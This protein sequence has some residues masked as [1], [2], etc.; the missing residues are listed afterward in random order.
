V[1]LEAMATGVPVV[2]ASAGGVPE[3]IRDGETGFLVRPDDPEA[4]ADALQRIW[5]D[6]SLTQAVTQRARKEIEA[7]FDLQRNI[8]ALIALL[9]GALNP[10]AQERSGRRPRRPFLTI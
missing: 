8:D 6:P 2:A 7:R 4:M 3:V 9:D 10:A 1:I 5:H